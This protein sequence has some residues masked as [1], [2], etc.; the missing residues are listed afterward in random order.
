MDIS[1]TPNSTLG[2]MLY[3]FSATAYEIDEC[4]V[5]NY[6]EYGISTIGDYSTYVNYIFD[7]A[8]Q[9]SGTFNG[10]GENVYTAIEEQ[11]NNNQTIT[12]Y[13]TEV[14][15]LSY[16][17]IEFQSDPYLIDADTL[18]PAGDG[19][20]NTILGYV[21]YINNQAIYVN[22]D[23]IYELA[24]D[25]VKVTSIWF[26]RETT[27]L[28]D[29]IAKV[30][31]YE[32]ETDIVT[33]VS[34]YV[35]AGQLQDVFLC[36]SSVVDLISEKYASDDGDTFQKILSIDQLS[37]EAEPGTVLYIKDSYDDNYYRHVIGD[38]GVLSFYDDE[39]VVT[40]FYFNGIHLDDL[41]DYEVNNEQILYNGQW[42]TLNEN[43]DVECPV[44]ALVDY[45][46]ELEKGVY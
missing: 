21:V 27:V 9:I 42:Y 6:N 37:I 1:F 43:N 14:D 32:A 19:S 45:I 13:A 36:G 23:G 35:K 34:Y 26:P 12:D 22:T 17:K 4:S 40:D 46:Y 30:E 39:A 29:F 3:S 20:T 8:S 24:G 33:Q 25:G 10:R 28:V 18:K 31:E 2:R 7:K 5:D 15:Y 38:T 16:V 11:I 41:S 44:E